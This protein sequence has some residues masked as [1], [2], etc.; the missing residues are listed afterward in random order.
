MKVQRK[1]KPE[2]ELDEHAGFEQDK[3]KTLC[4]RVENTGSLLPL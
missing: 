2:H 4:G 1:L 3:M